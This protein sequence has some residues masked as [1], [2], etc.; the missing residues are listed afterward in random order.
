MEL[1]TLGQKRTRES[2]MGK[3]YKMREI[4]YSRPRKNKRVRNANM[5]KC[6]CV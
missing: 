4:R 2:G 3:Q 6:E 5:I 1:E